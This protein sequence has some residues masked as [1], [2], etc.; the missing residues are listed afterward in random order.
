MKHLA[1]CGFVETD[2]LTATFKDI[3]ILKLETLYENTKMNTDIVE[4][5]MLK[6]VRILLIFEG[7]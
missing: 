4:G 5:R 6:F 3:T 2:H 7:K 1:V